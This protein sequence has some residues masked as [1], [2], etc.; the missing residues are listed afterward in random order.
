M[1][2][3]GLGTFDCNVP[4]VDDLPASQCLRRGLVSSTRDNKRDRYPVRWRSQPTPTPYLIVRIHTIA[5]APVPEHE[6][7]RYQAPPR[8]L[9]HVRSA[10]RWWHRRAVGGT[11]PL[12]GHCGPDALH[13]L[14]WVRAVGGTKPL[15][16]HCGRPSQKSR[17]YRRLRCY[18]REAP[19]YSHASSIPLPS[20][21]RKLIAP[22]HARGSGRLHHQFG[23]R[24]QVP[25][26]VLVLV[27]LDFAHLARGVFL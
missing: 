12:R 19:P 1:P 11:K 2:A 24:Q 3:K 7:R 27:P 25:S 5:R 26:C 20:W 16:G 22:Q 15:R 17:I 9:R 8:A 18:L 21:S 6:S 10:T 14:R 13:V 4:A 23:A